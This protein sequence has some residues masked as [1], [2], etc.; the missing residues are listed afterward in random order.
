MSSSTPQGTRLAGK[1]AI[2]TGG[3][4]G[5]GAAIATRYAQ[6]GA[7]VLIGDINVAGGEKTAAQS[8]TAMAFMKMDVTRLEDWNAAIE[9][10]TS[11]FGRVDVLVNNAGTTY[12]NKPTQD[13]TIEEFERVFDVNVRSIF[14]AS[15]TFIPKLIEQGQGGSIIN[16][17]STGAARPRPGLVWYNAS[18]GAVSNATKGLAAEYGSHQIRVNNVCPLLS[19]TGLFEMFV[20][21]PD[22]PENRAQFVSNVPLGRLTDPNDVANMCLYLG[23]DE[24]RFINGTDM[25]VDGGKCI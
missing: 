17:S 1:V 25:V 24:A 20:G 2:V 7:K 11:K 19:G 16:I 21:V 13:V 18:K 4:S 10:A 12:R 6:E 3:G 15:K 5:F 9:L 14:L 8:P 22:T 23:S